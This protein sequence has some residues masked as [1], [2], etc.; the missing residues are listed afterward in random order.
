MSMMFSTHTAE[1]QQPS[2]T[3]DAS[4]GDVNTWE[5]VYPSIMGNLQSA[6]GTA[7]SSVGKIV[8][9]F[10]RRGITISHAFYTQT[11]ITSLRIGCRAIIN[12]AIYLVKHVTDA[13]GRGRVFEC[14]MEKI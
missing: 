2:T 3:Q 1:F 12:A 5:T 8:N 4:G 7:S 6:S 10:M 9:D 14:Y 13:G 11:N